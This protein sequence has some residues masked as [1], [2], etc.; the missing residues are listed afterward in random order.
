MIKLDSLESTNPWNP[1]LGLYV[2]ITRHTEDGTV[3]TPNECLTREEALR[4]YTVNNAYLNHEEE[5]KGSLEVGK[6]GDLIV[7]DRDYLTCP[8]DDIPQTR[9]RYTIVGGRVVYERKD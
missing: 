4:L 6:L 1:W 8:V 2:A 3:L 5:D 9:V 7:I